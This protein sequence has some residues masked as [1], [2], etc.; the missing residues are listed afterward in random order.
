MG[1]P[2]YAPVGAGLSTP[3]FAAA[4]A[5]MSI[6]CTADGGAG[7]SLG[8]QATNVGIS[9]V[10]LVNEVW[11]AAGGAST[12]SVF[13]Y[14]SDLEVTGCDTGGLGGT[15]FGASIVGV[16]FNSAHVSNAPGD[17]SSISANYAA[18]PS[19]DEYAMDATCKTPAANPDLTYLPDSFIVLG[20]DSNSS[21]CGWR[22]AEIVRA[23]MVILPQPAGT[24]SELRATGWSAWFSL[25][26]FSNTSGTVMASDGLGL[27]VSPVTN[28]HAYNLYQ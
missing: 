14:C 8:P 24:V 21:T 16:Q 6:T 27:F 23:N 17:W 11:P 15:G 28:K 2:L 19:A 13:G 7:S 22:V 9:N 3:T 5:V 4:Q 18:A 26:M 20:S 25:A 12:L 1:V 10:G